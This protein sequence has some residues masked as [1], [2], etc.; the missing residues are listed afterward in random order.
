MRV[1]RHVVNQVCRDHPGAR[2]VDFPVERDLQNV[3]RRL[4]RVAGDVPLARLLKASAFPPGRIEAGEVTP[5]EA[6]RKGGLAHQRKQQ[7]EFEMPAPPP[8][9]DT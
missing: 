1:A 2:L 4:A 3:A 7:E 8:S 6:G 5:R 9:R